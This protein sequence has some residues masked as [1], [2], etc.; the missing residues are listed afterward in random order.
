MRSAVRALSVARPLATGRVLCSV[1]SGSL[2]EVLNVREF[3][4]GHVG[5]VVQAVPTTAAR[6]PDDRIR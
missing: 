2:L 6:V 5:V 1:V 3:G 4:R